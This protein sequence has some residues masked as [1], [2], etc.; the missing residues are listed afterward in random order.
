MLAELGYRFAIERPEIDETPWPDEAAA[1]YVERLALAKAEAVARAV[2]TGSGPTRHGYVILAADTVVTLD[3]VLLGKPEDDA[4]A[5][6]MLAR[7]AGRRHEVLTSIAVLAPG[8]GL[9]AAHVEC[10]GVTIGG[11]DDQAIGWYVASGEPHDKAGAYAIQ[12]LGAVFV[13]RIDG[14]YSNV[15][16]LPLPATCRLLARAGI[17]LPASRD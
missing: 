5:A 2:D 14:N 8:T 11:L 3:G 12:G 1:P 4:D 16:G 7:L 9:R 6:R 10:T 17:P 15:V 13:E